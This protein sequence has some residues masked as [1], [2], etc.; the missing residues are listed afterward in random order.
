[1]YINPKKVFNPPSYVNFRKLSVINRAA[2]LAGEPG[3]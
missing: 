2:S 3:R 1:M